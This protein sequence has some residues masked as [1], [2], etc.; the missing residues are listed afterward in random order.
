MPICAKGEPPTMAG[1]GAGPFVMTSTNAAS[2]S[3]FKAF[4]NYYRAGLP[5]LG[6][7]K[8]SSMRTK[9]CA[10]PRCSRA[11]STSSNMCPGSRWHSI[12]QNAEAGAADHRRPVHVPDLQRRAKPF[13]DPRVRRAIAHAIKR[14]DIVS[15]AFYGRGGALEAPADR[16]GQRLLR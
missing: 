16:R 2:R 11:M 3:A 7:I 5:K 10:S 1:A 14:E 12:E 9:T 6:T 13:G 4:D 15:A 8:T